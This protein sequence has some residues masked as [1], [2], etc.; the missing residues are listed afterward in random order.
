MMVYWD[1]YPASDDTTTAGTDWEEFSVIDRDY[2]TSDPEQ[3]K[4]LYWSWL[5]G[6]GSTTGV[7]CINKIM[8]DQA[9]HLYVDVVYYS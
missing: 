1:K 7:Y 9:D 8:Y 3:M 4:E 2:L 6:M 5:S